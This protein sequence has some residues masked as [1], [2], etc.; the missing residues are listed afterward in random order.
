M[1]G[2]FAIFYCEDCFENIC[3][4]CISD[5]SGHRFVKQEHS[6]NLLKDRLEKV[7]VD[8]NKMCQTINAGIEKSSLKKERFELKITQ[9]MQEIDDFCDELIRVINTKRN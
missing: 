6:A 4:G 5:H 3:A 9:K 7:A 8:M 1:R 2:E